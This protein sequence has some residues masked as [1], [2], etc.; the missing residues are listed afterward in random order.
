MNLCKAQSFE[1]LPERKCTKSHVVSHTKLATYD[2]EAILAEVQ[3]W[4]KG[5]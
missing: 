4:P 3:E 1:R 5:K 2:T